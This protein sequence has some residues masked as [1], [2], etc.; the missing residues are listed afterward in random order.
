MASA[1]TTAPAATPLWRIRVGDRSDM[2]FHLRDYFRRLG[3]AAE[4]SSPTEVELATDVLGSELGK[5]LADW[6]R[7]IDV[8]ARFVD[9]PARLASAESAARPI[10]RL[11]SLLT[12]KGFITESQ[13]ELALNESRE[14]GEM[15]GLLLV[16]KQWIFEEELARTLSE[17][18]SLPYVSVG[19]LGVNP[20]VARL[21][22]REVGENAAAI[23]VRESPDAV[24]V[25]FA[26]PTD[27]R[28]LEAVEAYIDPV[29]IVVAELSD[30]RLAWRS[31]PVTG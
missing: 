30:I 13:L 26:D 31:V 27:Q 10:P 9:R 5:Y 20:K 14:T 4:V 24:Q 19:R 6:V 22:P 3:I 8:P 23:P 12:A 16:R 17:Q 25:A 29:Q 2:V 28:A 18:L 1:D 15:L 11:G 7:V 21:L